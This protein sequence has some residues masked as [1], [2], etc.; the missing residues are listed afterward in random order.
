MARGNTAGPLDAPNFNGTSEWFTCLPSTN[1]HSARRSGNNL[2]VRFLNP[3]KTGPGST[4]SYIG[5]GPRLGELIKAP[6]RGKFV[7]RVLIPGYFAA[8]L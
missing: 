3:E 1:V 4:Y 2:H 8:R 7:R 5:A 6:S